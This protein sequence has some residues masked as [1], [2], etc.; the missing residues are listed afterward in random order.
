MI[1]D[2]LGDII[3]EVVGTKMNLIFIARLCIF[4][5]YLIYSEKKHS[6]HK[7][8]S[9]KILIVNSNSYKTG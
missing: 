1:I 9:Y 7:T 3:V 8:N 4:R 6:V 2:K 5:T